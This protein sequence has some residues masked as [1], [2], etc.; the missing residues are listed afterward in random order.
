[1]LSELFEPKPDLKASYSLMDAS[2]V[3]IDS[4]HGGTIC[5]ICHVHIQDKTPS[6][7]ARHIK[8]KMH[9]SA[10]KLALSELPVTDSFLKHGQ[11]ER[12]DLLADNGDSS[13]TFFQDITT[14]NDQWE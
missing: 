12:N 9:Q 8:T 14:L 10:I 2:L 6:S 3:F 1:M 13:E 5:S 7:K 11:V 4:K